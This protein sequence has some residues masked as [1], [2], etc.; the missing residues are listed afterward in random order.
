MFQQLE[1]M[2]SPPFRRESQAR[3]TLKNI[4]RDVEWEVPEVF[5]LLEAIAAWDTETERG[6]VRGDMT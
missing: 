4:R 1:P 5:Y 3:Q 6:D 2:V